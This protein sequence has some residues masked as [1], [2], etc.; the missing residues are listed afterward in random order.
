VLDYVVGSK[1]SEFLLEMLIRAWHR[2]ATYSSGGKIDYEKGMLEATFSPRD[3]EVFAKELGVSFSVTLGVVHGDMSRAVKLRQPVDNL[4]T[5]SLRRNDL[6]D[7]VFFKMTVAPPSSF[8][9][10]V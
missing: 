3:W 6:E 1:E 4:G 10:G 8:S 5:P 7:P 2:L 9:Q